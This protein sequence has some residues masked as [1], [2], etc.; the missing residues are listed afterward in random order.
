MTVK[1]F[2]SGVDGNY[3]EIYSKFLNDDKIR[4]YLYIFLQDKT[5]TNLCIEIDSKNP[6]KAFI[7]AHTLKVLSQNLSF[8]SLYICSEKVTQ[9]LKNNN[10]QKAITILPELSEE[11]TR[12]ILGIKKLK[13]AE[14]STV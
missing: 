5:F 4:K 14:C 8:S 6:Q 13:E 10:L 7:Y 12:V 1:E 11:Y 9:A 2:Y 3:M